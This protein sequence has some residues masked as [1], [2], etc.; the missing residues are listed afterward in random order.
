MASPM[1]QDPYAALQKAATAKRYE[2]PFPWGKLFVFLI[3]AGGFGWSFYQYY[4]QYQLPKERILVDR[5]GKQMNVRVEEK[6]GQ[7]LKMTSLSDGSTQFFPISLLSSKDQTFFTSVKTKATIPFP[8]VC[9]LKKPDGTPMMVSIKGYNDYFVDYTTDT[10]PADRFIT[11][12][13]L[14]PF[15]KALIKT[16]AK[17]LRVGFPVDWTLRTPSGKDVPVVLTNKDNVYLQYYIPAEKNTESLHFYPINKLTPET[18]DLVNSLSTIQQITDDTKCTLTDKSGRRV[19]VK[20]LTRSDDMVKFVSVDDNKTY[21]FPIANLSEL[22]QLFVKSVDNNL[23]DV[24]DLPEL[25]VTVQIARTQLIDLDKKITN[26]QNE[27]TR[28]DLQSE[29][30]HPDSTQPEAEAI[31]L[32]INAYRDEAKH[33]IT[34]ILNDFEKRIDALETQ[35]VAL[36]GKARDPNSSKEEKVSLQN[37]ILQNNDLVGLLKREMVTVSRVGE[38]VKPV[39]N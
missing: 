15:D 16:M 9:T 36:E 1:P 37:Q 31:K 17:S 39:V 13:S 7:A 33:Y 18:R 34:Q 8:Y 19:Y 24:W 23:T 35:N 27:L 22:D 12:D 25:P 3:V 30:N 6:D 21:I 38:T 4:W 26:L 14:Q 28:P 32:Q 11:I 20:V 29:L 10:D 5:D 2:S